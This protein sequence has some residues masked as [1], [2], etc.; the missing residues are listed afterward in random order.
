MGVVSRVFPL[1]CHTSITYTCFS[2]LISFEKIMTTC[3]KRNLSGRTEIIFAFI[4]RRSER[5]SRRLV[6]YNMYMIMNDRLKQEPRIV[7]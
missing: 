6:L 5:L 3:F 1:T 2:R 4:G 7:I